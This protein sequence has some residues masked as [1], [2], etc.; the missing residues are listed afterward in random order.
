MIEFS[1]SEQKLIN[2]LLSIA[3]KHGS[4]LR[5]AGGFVRDKLLS[6]NSSDIDIV[7]DNMSGKAFAEL[8]QAEQGY[9]HV[10]VL[11]ARPDQS[12][13]LET[14]M[15]TVHGFDIDFAS[16]R[17]ETYTSTRIPQIEPGSP[18]E[19]AERRDLTINSIFYNINT[20]VIEDY[21]GGI[22]DLKNN[23]ARTPVDAEKTFM[24]DPLRILRIIR[25]CAKYSLIP[26]EEIIL[27]ANLEHVQKSFKEKISKERIWK[28]VVGQKINDN[29]WKCGFITDVNAHAAMRLVVDFGFMDILFSPFN[30]KLNNW[31]TDQNSPHHD[32]NILEH[33]LKAF[34]YLNNNFTQN[35][36]IDR[37]VIN[38]SL[39]LH[40]LGK[41]DPD[42][43][44]VHP[45]GHYQYKGH[46]D[47]SIS[48]AQLVLDQLGAPNDISHRVLRLVAQ[49]MRYHALEDNCRDKPLRKIVKDMGNDWELLLQHSSADA[50]GKINVAN[51]TKKRYDDFHTRTIELLKEQGNSTSIKRPITGYD[52]MKIGIKQ[53][54]EM[55][56]LFQALDEKL[57]DNPS[58]TK[59]ESIN[60]ILEIINEKK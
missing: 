48:L 19:D 46:D 3:N 1:K 20:G 45:N 40:D 36:Y 4:I 47:R 58:L 15:L 49:H 53:G 26:T 30:L 52:L 11:E 37:A 14:A 13:H 21:T 7:I 5:I 41:R 6:K 10:S 55:G 34:E 54:P 50:H 44:Q 27:A 22:E 17:K 18:Q 59:E 28:E 51:G 35:S 24:D 9:G 33:T 8:V 32:L 25:F 16:L 42:Y 12:K 60:Y 23:I 57:L 39:I 56:E 31:N 43:I 2:Y 29:Q 38:L